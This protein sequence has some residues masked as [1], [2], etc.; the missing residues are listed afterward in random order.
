MT[1]G[2]L[3]GPRVS[4]GVRA[5][6]SGLGPFPMSI[7]TGGF[8][9][10]SLRRSSVARRLAFGAVALATV[11]PVALSGALTAPASAAQRPAATGTINIGFEASES[12]VLGTFGASF[13]HG[14]QVAVDELNKA[15]GVTVGGKK[16]DFNLNVCNDNSDQTQVASC[17]DQLVETDHD[18]FIFGGLADFGPIVHGITEANKVIYFSTGSAVASLMSTSHYTVNTVPS[19]AAR[20]LMSVEAFHYLYP[21]AKTVALLGN[22]DATDQAAFAAL[23]PAFKKVG[24]KLV[25]T[26]VAPD[27][28]TDFSSLLTALKADHP[29]VIWNELAAVDSAEQEMLTQNGQLQASKIIFN[30]SGSC[31]PS[32]PKTPG[33][34]YLG[35]TN[36]GAIA[37][38]PLVTSA[39]KQYQKDY[40]Q[41]KGAP[42]NPDPN[43]STALYIYDFFP[44]LKL[45]IA[46]AGSVSNVSAV[47][48]AVNEI[49]YTGVNGKITVSHDQASYGQVICQ[50]KNGNSPFSEIE[51]FPNGSHTGLSSPK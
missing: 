18:K 1:T 30:N 5:L 13:E 12:G 17:T 29:D 11:V 25:G 51:F 22:Q 44:L 38:G 37:V 16:Y 27:D 26:Q 14:A 46:K 49:S 35:E 34:S 15:G 28:V 40:Y 32:Y 21:K 47:L 36:T 31:L 23:T 42:S 19:L 48:K 2:G 41:V 33:I 43:I 6:D 3:K 20:S 4:A 10:N 8:S 24:L 50:S 7:E 45:A 39:E 9:V